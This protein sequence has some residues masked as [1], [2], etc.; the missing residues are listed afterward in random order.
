MSEG[1][2]IHFPDN[3]KSMSM[4]IKCNRRIS[5]VN[6]PFSG[7]IDDV[8]IAGAKTLRTGPGVNHLLAR[9]TRRE[10]GLNIGISAI[11]AGSRFP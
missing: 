7:R 10:V 11:T 9:Q 6:R 8:T 2:L 1:V 5:S 3:I 4:I